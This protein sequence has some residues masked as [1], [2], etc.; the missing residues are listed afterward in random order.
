MEEL[1]WFLNDVAAKNGWPL[2]AQCLA[3]LRKIIKKQEVMS[4]EVLLRPPQVCE[5]LYF[6]KK[7]L[8][9]C[10]YMLHG[11][12][13]CDWFFGEMETVVSIDSFYD[14]LPSIDFIQAIEDCILYYITYRE[15]DYLYQNYV[16]FNV[17]GRV[18]TNKYL[19]IWHKQAKNIRMLTAEE[20]YQFLLDTQPGLV[21]RVSIKDLSSH[22][23]MARE[24]LSRVRGRI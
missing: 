3:H 21:N 4:E 23:D 15:L 5:H 16:E 10:Y 8:L 7:G 20:R 18:L 22:L 11:Q 1:L 19:R 24:T 9:K 12:E 13:V 6:I 14:Q 17:V 2:S